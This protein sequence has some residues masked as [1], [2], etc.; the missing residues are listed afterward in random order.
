MY[1]I[2]YYDSNKNTGFKNPKIIL[3]LLGLNLEQTEHETDARR[4]IKRE[5]KI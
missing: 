5:T 3:N 2:Y 1:C 4:F